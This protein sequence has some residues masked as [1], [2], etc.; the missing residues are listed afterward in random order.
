LSYLWLEPKV[1]E[2]EVVW[3]KKKDYGTVPKYLEKLK[4]QMQREY[5]YVR[6]LQQQE[7]EQQDEEKYILTEDEIKE[8]REGLKTKWEF[9]NKKYQLLTHKAVLDTIGLRRRFV[10]Y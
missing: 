2:Q 3:T 8:L 6:S 9:V 10:L 4:E 7:Q 1:I 5:D